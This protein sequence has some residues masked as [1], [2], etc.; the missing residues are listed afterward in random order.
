MGLRPKPRCAHSPRKGEDGEGCRQAPPSGKP[1]RASLCDSRS[2][3]EKSAFMCNSV[4][5]KSIMLYLETVLQD[6]SPDRA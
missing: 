4:R 1:A 6:V 5:I 3:D 2:Y